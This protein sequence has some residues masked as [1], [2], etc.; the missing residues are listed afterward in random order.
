MKKNRIKLLSTIILAL[1]LVACGN[2]NSKETI[3]ETQKEVSLQTI[4]ETE[5]KEKEEFSKFELEAKLE[6]YDIN[7]SSKIIAKITDTKEKE[8]TFSVM[9]IKKGK[10]KDQFIL[11]KDILMNKEYVISLIP[12]INKDGSINEIKNDFKINTSSKNFTE[13]VNSKFTKKEDVTKAQL[14][15][16]IKKTTVAVQNGDETLINENGKKVLAL[17]NTNVKNT[18]IAKKDDIKVV[19]VKAIQETS[20]ETI[21]ETPK[22]IAKETDKET[23]KKDSKPIKKETQKEQPKPTET[24]KKVETPKETQKET[25][26]PQ[27]KQKKKVWVVDVKSQ[28]PVYKKKWVVDVKGQ[29]PVYKNKC[30]ITKQAWTETTDELIDFDQIIKPRWFV[31]TDLGTEYF[32][33]SKEAENRSIELLHKGYTG[34]WGTAEDEV[35]ITNK[36]YKTI[37]HPAEESCSKVLVKEKVEEKG[38]YENVLVKEKVEE[39][40]HWE[41]R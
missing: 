20:K 25:N 18:E 30:V 15:D 29:D 31:K 13:K 7:K 39:K 8:D 36:K 11:S 41:Y 9:D 28:E 17:V 34:N 12:S 37:K 4:E 19:D 26:K 16:I 1:S 21:K 2:N 10:E 24:P 14:E 3:K 40:G 22:E 6:N 38:H 33:S 5:T 35:I 32:Y 27:E 23:N